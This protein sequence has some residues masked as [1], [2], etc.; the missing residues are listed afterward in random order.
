MS[1][2]IQNN[3]I[4]SEAEMVSGEAFLF[5]KVPTDPRRLVTWNPDSKGTINPHL[6][7]VGGSGAGKTRLLK[8][9]IQYLQIKGKQIYVIDFH[10]DIDTPGENVYRFTSRN[11][12]YGLNPFEFEHDFENGGIDIQAR[13][14]TATFKRSFIK[15]LGDKQRSVLMQFLRDCYAYVGIH[16]DDTSTWNKPLPTI[17][18]LKE[19]YNKINEKINLGEGGSYYDSIATLI[20]LK[21]GLDRCNDSEEKEKII[22]KI[23]K[24]FADFEEYNKAF[25]QFLTEDKNKDL[26]HFN[27]GNVD[28]SW[29]LEKENAKTF[30]SLAPYMKDIHAS[31]V[32]NDNKPKITKGVVR[33]DISGYTNVDEPSEAIFFADVIAQRIFRSVKMRGEYRNLHL[34]GLADTFIIADESKLILPKGAEKDNPYHILHRIITE[35][36]KYGLGWI[37][38]SQRPNHFSEEMTSSIGTKVVLQINKNDIANAVRCLGVQ[39][40]EMFNQLK[41]TGIGLVGQLGKDF[42][43]VALPWAEFK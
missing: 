2:T 32:F 20:K 26:F 13:I 1:E 14:L 3:R 16:D 10:G 39:N 37:G 8:K 19:L 11:S 5:G 18:T 36:R 34:P 40:A 25:Y 15:S 12:K 28:V 4:I 35:S 42:K 17:S 7:I 38:A 43:T 22:V 31:P 41:A 33:F 29:Y 21:E 27:V 30:K 23:D 6:L 9:I 24:K